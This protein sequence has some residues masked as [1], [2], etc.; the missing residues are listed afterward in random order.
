[1]ALGFRKSEPSDVPVQAVLS[2]R[3][4]GLS[5]EEIIDQLRDQGF[6][7]QAI[8]DAMSQAEVKSAAVTPKM[9]NNS[10]PRA[11]QATKTAPKPFPSIEEPELPPLPGE[12]EGG[13]P[14]SSMFAEEEKIESGKI[15][16]IERV[17]EEIVNEKWKDVT[18][19]FSRMEES[20]F[21]TEAEV[22]SLSKK[23]EELTTRL[24]KL[25]SILMG[26]VEEYHKTMQDV[27][28][29][30]RALEKVMQKLVPS[31]AEQIKAL[32]DVVVELKGPSA[33]SL[34]E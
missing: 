15:E 25:N 24:D 30:V 18:D 7:L 5:N 26:R 13:M 23:V 29:E 14:E 32:K 12:E 8:R 28:V 34:E 27:D 10:M 16:E 19:K 3:S 33:R 22:K 11:S 2:L 4:Q 21:K 9:N 31:M 17:L 1:M 6:N 20:R